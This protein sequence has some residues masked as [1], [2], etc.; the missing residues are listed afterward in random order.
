MWKWNVR[1]ITDGQ[2]QLE[3]LVSN[4]IKDD[5]GP[6]EQDIIDPAF[7]RLINVQSDYLYTTKS[8]WQ[9]YWQWIIGV[10]VSLIGFGYSRYDKYQEEK[11][12]KKDEY[13][14]KLD[15]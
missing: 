2:H 3:L 11:K 9:Q 4:R 7:E 12:K 13:L 6:A 15:N 1:P 5:D 8:F 14:K 10:A